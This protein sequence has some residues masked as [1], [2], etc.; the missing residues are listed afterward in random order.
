[1]NTIPGTETG[2]N[3][4]VDQDA[5]QNEEN[6]LVPSAVDENTTTNIPISSQRVSRKQRI[7]EQR[8][9]T[10]FEILKS[11]VSSNDEA[12]DFGN[13]I[14]KKLRTYDACTRSAVQHAIMGIFLKVDMGNFEQQPALARS[15]PGN[16]QHSL[17]HFSFPA[18]NI[19]SVSH[20]NQ[21]SPSF[22]SRSASSS[23]HLTGQ[24]LLK[25]R[26]ALSTEQLPSISPS[27]STEQLPSISPSTSSSPLPTEQNVFSPNLSEDDYFIQE[28]I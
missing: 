19:P 21:P 7:Q 27:T 18:V 12:Q 4:E 24:Q 6:L 8:L 25:T 3:L 2:D 5:S 20:F 15:R 17:Q 9:D 13:L 23:P 22:D 14:A 16:D 28:L 26:S 1:M 10:A 11:S